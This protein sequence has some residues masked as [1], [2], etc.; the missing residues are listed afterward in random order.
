M[1]FILNFV[2]VVNHMYSFADVKPILCPKNKSYLIMVYD[3]FKHTVELDCYYFVEDFST[4]VHQGYWPVIFF[5][6]TILL[7]S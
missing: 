1:F 7:W 6:C 2:N 4:Y 3:P 5:S